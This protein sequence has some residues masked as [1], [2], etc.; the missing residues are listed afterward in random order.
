[1]TLA[2]WLLLAS[3]MLCPPAEPAA[4]WLRDD[5]TVC[6]GP[7]LPSEP[8]EAPPPIEVAEEEDDDEKALPCSL[9]RSGDQVGP[10]AS[11]RNPSR[12][13]LVP[14]DDRAHGPQRAPPAP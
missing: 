6:S 8:R 7:L 4:V 12:F 14:P 3:G 5:L 9:G 11:L 10:V 1:M 13:P 2:P